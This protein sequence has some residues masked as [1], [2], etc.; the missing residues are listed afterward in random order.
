MAIS[1]PSGVNCEYCKR[2]SSP[3]FVTA[4]IQEFY[5]LPIAGWVHIVK[6]SPLKVEPCNRAEDFDRLMTPVSDKGDGND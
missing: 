2:G 6:I 3:W 1:L 4:D 5:D